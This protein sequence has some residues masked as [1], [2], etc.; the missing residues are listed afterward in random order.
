[1]PVPDSVTNEILYIGICSVFKGYPS[2][3]N[4][5]IR[6]PVTR[7]KNKYPVYPD[8]APYIYC[9][10]KHVVSTYTDGRYNKK[11]Q[12]VSGEL[13]I[14]SIDSVNRKL[15][16]T[17]NIQYRDTVTKET[18]NISN[19]KINLNTWIRVGEPR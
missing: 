6:V 19:G 18:V 11:Y 14:I 3:R 7:N 15:E 17:F 10:D 2:L 5:F 13:N 1:M 16:A 12:A 9:G 8:I 4:V